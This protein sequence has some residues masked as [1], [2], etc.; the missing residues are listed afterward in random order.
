MSEITR[1]GVELAKS[2]IQVNA[3]DAGGKES[4]PNRERTMH[5]KSTS[6]LAAMLP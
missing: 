5:P 3:V 2:V 6:E 4:E 1:V